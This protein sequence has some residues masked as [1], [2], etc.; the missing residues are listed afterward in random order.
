MAVSVKFMPLLVKR[1]SSK[2]DAYTVPYAEGMRPADIIRAE[3]FAEHDAEAIMVL[4]NSVQQ[5]LDT[6][7]KDGDTVEF[8][9]GIQGGDR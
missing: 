9:V 7:L 4:I 5:D 1:T 2:R 3:G 8:M 6:A